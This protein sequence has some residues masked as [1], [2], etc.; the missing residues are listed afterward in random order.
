MRSLVPVGHFRSISGHLF[1]WLVCGSFR[2]RHGLLFTDCIVWDDKNNVIGFKISHWIHLGRWSTGSP[3]LQV[4]QLSKHSHVSSCRLI[5]SPVYFPWNMTLRYKMQISDGSWDKILHSNLSTQ[6][7]SKEDFFSGGLSL[8]TPKF[9]RKF[10]RLL[11]KD[12]R[13]S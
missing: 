9:R 4:F 3:K 11:R 5:Y 7:F 2:W 8:G 13:R 1:T 6:C 12:Y 10:S